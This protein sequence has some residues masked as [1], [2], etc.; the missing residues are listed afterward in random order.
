MDSNFFRWWWGLFLLV[1]LVLGGADWG[2]AGAP[3]PSGQPGAGPQPGAG[4]EEFFRGVFQ[5]VFGGVV[6]GTLRIAPNG[7]VYLHNRYGEYNRSAPDGVSWPSGPGTEAFRIP[8]QDLENATDAQLGKYADEILSKTEVPYGEVQL[9]KTSQ[10]SKL[11]KQNI[12]SKLKE[13]RDTYRQE[14]KAGRTPATDIP[15]DQYFKS[16]QE[17]K[18][19]R[20]QE[21]GQKGAMKTT[22]GVPSA[23]AS[24]AG[25][26]PR[27][28]EGMYVELY[29]GASFIGSSSI[30]PRLSNTQRFGN[31]T[32]ITNTNFNFPGRVNP[33]PQIGVKIGQWGCPMMARERPFWNYLGWNLD[34]SYQNYS[35]PRQLGTYREIQFLN[36]N[37]VSQ[38]EGKAELFG[39][40]GF[41]NISWQLNVR[42]GFLPTKEKPFGTVQPFVGVGPT[43]VINTLE[44]TVGFRE[45]TWFNNQPVMIPLNN[46]LNFGRQTDVSVGLKVDAGVRYFPLE[47]VFLDVGFQWTYAMPSFRLTRGSSLIDFETEINRFGVNIGLGYQF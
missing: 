40:G 8:R 4:A 14:A 3:R 22:P 31:N 2:L 7:D 47:N 38:Q 20:A 5:N 46:D 42:Y 11:T 45:V 24:Y 26:T 19:K 35:I 13:A 27:W 15:V 10:T 36:G 18:S 32:F 33:A 30:T 23:G 12:I 34:L 21:K 37:P 17:A 44:P 9:G 16:V 43:V 1:A 39:D 29:G 41:L 28:M 25:V 6:F